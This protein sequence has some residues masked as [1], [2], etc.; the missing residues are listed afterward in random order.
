MAQRSAEYEPDRLDQSTEIDRNSQTTVKRNITRK[1]ITMR[2][3]VD[4]FGELK[5]IRQVTNIFRSKMI[6]NC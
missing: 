5:E 6:K 1:Q 3:F 4:F 2:G